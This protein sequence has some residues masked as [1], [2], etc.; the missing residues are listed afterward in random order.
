VRFVPQGWRP[1][2]TTL[3]FFTL[4]G[5]VLFALWRTAADISFDA[6]VAALGSLRFTT[7]LSALAATLL[8][9]AVL[10]GYDFLALRYGGIRLPLL[11]ILLASFCGYA[12]GNAIGLGMFSGGAVRY[13][14]YSAAGLS[15]LQIAGLVSFISFAFGIG[16][17]TIT[18]ICIEL[19]AHEIR[20]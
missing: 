5:I 1:L 17:F 7:L 8:S 10:V 15:S 18:S 11:T 14:F 4:G 6:L 3:A 9:Y 12:I 13:R 20:P 19:R 16:T 2:L